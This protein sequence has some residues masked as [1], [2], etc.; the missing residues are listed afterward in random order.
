METVLQA[1][2]LVRD[3]TRTLQFGCATPESSTELFVCYFWQ[4]TFY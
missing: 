2:K 3:A 4:V 1:A